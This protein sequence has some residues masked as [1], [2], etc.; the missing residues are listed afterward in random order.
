M[1]LSKE[2]QLLALANKIKK[3][4]HEERK[5]L[6]VKANIL[7]P[8]GIYHPDFFRKET[9]QYSQRQVLLKWAKSLNIIYLDELL[10]KLQELQYPA[11]VIDYFK[12]FKEGTH[13]RY[14]WYDSEIAK[15]LDNL[16]L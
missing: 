6:L 10:L 9:V 7:T 1:A 12:N 8:E 16:N 3:L 4:S 11:A 13:T 14:R 5:L 15:E 2:Q